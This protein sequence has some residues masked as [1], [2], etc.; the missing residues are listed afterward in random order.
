MISRRPL[1]LRRPRP[2]AHPRNHPP[3]AWAR[4]ST[5]RNLRRRPVAASFPAS[6][7]MTGITFEDGLLRSRAERR[8]AHDSARKYATGPSVLTV[9]LRRSHHAARHVAADTIEGPMPDGVAAIMVPNATECGQRIPAA[10]QGHPSLT[11]DCK[12]STTC[13]LTSEARGPPANGP[14][15]RGDDPSCRHRSILA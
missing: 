5:Y 14:P 10:G 1:T 2:A 15:P 6:G 12:P 8:F 7:P 4:R 9:C 3:A 11:Q 13:K